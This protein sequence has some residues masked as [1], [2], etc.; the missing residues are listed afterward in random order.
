MESGKAT[1]VGLH[2]KV[3][4]DFADRF[5][6]FACRVPLRFPAE[7]T[8]DARVGLRDTLGICRTSRVLRSS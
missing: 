6:M 5:E 2:L 1:A 8:L 3:S 7:I 4:S